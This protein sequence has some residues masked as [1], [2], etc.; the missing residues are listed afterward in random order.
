[1][2]SRVLIL[3]DQADFRK[4]LAEALGGIFRIDEAADEAEFRRKFRPFRYDLILLDMRLSVDREGI[5]VLRFVYSMDSLQP[6]IVVSGF[7]NADAAIEAVNAGALMFLHKQEFTPLQLIR[8]AEA[9]IQQGRLRREVQSL[10]HLAW[11]HEPDYLIGQ[12]PDIREAR[13]RIQYFASHREPVPLVV[14][15]RGTGTSLVSRMIHRYSDCKGSLVEVQASEFLESVMRSGAIHSDSWNRSHDGTLVLDRIETRK[16]EVQRWIESGKTES[17]NGPHIV[18]LSKEKGTTCA[19]DEAVRLPPLRDRRRD[20]PL[21]VN[22][23]LHQQR[24]QGG[25]STV[26]VVEEEVMDRFENHAWEG[27]VRE[28]KNAVEFATIRAGTDE[29]PTLQPKHLP[30]TIIESGARTIKGEWNYQFQISRAEVDFVN[31]AVTRRGIHTKTKLADELGYSDRFT[32]LRRIR[33]AL[34]DHPQLEKE[35]P[36]VAELFS[37]A[38]SR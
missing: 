14:G 12:H 22:H 18:L 32:L 7:G 38:R 10:R 27:N 35:F 4:V 3:D 24:H 5:D 15:E 17:R 2:T 23:F 25:S 20:I 34:T 6:V 37:G 29:A 31:Q 33:K 30:Q 8:M 11:E 21:L 1:M 36:I 28:L 16:T 19:S 9:V 26:S 13:E